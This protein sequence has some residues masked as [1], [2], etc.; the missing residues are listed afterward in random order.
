MNMTSKSIKLQ[1]NNC[2]NLYNVDDNPDLELHI[3]FIENAGSIKCKCKFQTIIVINNSP[4]QSP[5]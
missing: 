5:F 3:H 2:Y 4:A 1:T